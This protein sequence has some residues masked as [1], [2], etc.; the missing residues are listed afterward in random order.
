MSSGSEI[1]TAT[2]SIGDRRADRA[3]TAPSARHERTARACAPRTPGSI[4]NLTSRVPCLAGSPHKSLH[5]MA[6]K[7]TIQ[8]KSVAAKAAPKK[9]GG[10]STMVKIEACKS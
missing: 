5:A 10:G 2:D 1:G 6:P 3:P 7:K 9:A 8:K 4:V